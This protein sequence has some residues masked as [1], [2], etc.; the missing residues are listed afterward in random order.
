MLLVPD[1]LTF[2]NQTQGLVY[3]LFAHFSP[4]EQLLSIRTEPST[5]R[6]F[7]PFEF[8]LWYSDEFGF[9]MSDI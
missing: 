4:I 8:E 3:G 5:A 9:L 7:L 6:D 2:E 1:T